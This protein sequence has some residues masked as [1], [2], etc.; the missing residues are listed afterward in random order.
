ML[1]GKKEPVAAWRVTDVHAEVLGRVRRFET[2]IVGR[3]DELAL[4]RQAWVRALASRACHLFTVLGPAGVGKTRL[5]R[6]FLR[7]L[8]DEAAVLIG[9]C[10]PYGEGITFWPL[11]EVVHTLGDIRIYVDEADAA[12]IE[13]AVGAR[14]MQVAPEETARSVRRLVESVAS[15]WPLVLV[16][17][18]IHWGEP[19]LLDLIDHIAGARD[20][21]IL[22]LCLARPELL[23]ERPSWGG[24]KVNAT[25]ILLEPLDAEHSDELVSNLA[26]GARG[27]RR[28]SRSPRSPRATRSSSR[29]WSR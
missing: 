5:G 2:K 26:G 19:A 23:D 4:L 27:R 7:D 13:T 8:G 17:E 11:R 16:F 22:L 9:R 29:R 24:G 3:E 18:D 6:E 12:V 15:E 10:L 21:P 1:K 25:T 20:A 14:D 28:A